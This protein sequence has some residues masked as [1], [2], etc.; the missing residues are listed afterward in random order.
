MINY[1]LGILFLAGFGLAGSDG[2]W[3]PWP[4][5]AGVAFL[6]FFV[7]ISNSTISYGPG[8]RDG[9]SSIRGRTADCEH[10]RRKRMS[11]RDTHGKSVLRSPTSWTPDRDVFG[12]SL[13]GRVK[14]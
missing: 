11:C 10:G 1:L 14:D 6:G 2:E 12:P 5:L 13:N 9:S 4:N 3:F 8:A 7:I